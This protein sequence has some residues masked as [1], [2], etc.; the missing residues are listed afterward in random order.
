VARFVEVHPR[1]VGTSI[2]GIPVVGYPDLGPPSE[3]HVLVAV[4]AKGARAEIRAWLGERGYLEG[5]HFTCVA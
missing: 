1:K 4:G 5:E 2:G 3:E